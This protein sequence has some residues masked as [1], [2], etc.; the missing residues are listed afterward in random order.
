MTAAQPLPCLLEL[1]L[2]KGTVN[3]PNLASYNKRLVMVRAVC[4]VHLDSLI[5]YRRAR[6]LSHNAEAYTVFLP[7]REFETAG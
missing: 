6:R 4:R 2:E 7:P 5:P 1:G 3:R